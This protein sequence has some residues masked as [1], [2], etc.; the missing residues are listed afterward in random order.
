MEVDLGDP[1][2]RVPKKL[3]DRVQVAFG[4]I[5]DVGGECMARHMGLAVP[6]ARRR[7]HA[8]P[9]FVEASI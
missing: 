3:F 6:D 2:R 7:L 5:E 4:R 9:P 1:G 8:L